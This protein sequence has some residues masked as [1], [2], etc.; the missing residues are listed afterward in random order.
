MVH[1]VEFEQ[2]ARE[3]IK[4][5]VAKLAHA[6]RTTLGP[7][8]RNVII[9]KSFG[10]PIVTKD[11][12]TVAQEIELED[13]Y[14]NVGAQMVREVASKTSDVAG[15][16][17]TTATVLA[18]AIFNEGLKVTTAG[19]NP[20][21]LARGMEK[22]V[23]D[24]VAK[25]RTWSIPVKGRK[26]MAQVA[27]IAANNDSQI[28]GS[29]ADAI[30]KVGKDGVV[31][32]EEG[33]TLTIDLECV[34]GMR[35]K[36]GYLSP[37]F[38][39]N[40][41]RMEC[42]L[43]D[44]Y[45]LI[46]EKKLSHLQELLPLLEM[47]AE[48]GKP[49]LIIAENV[50]GEVL[51]T[52]VINRLRGTFSSCAV[53]A[54]AYGDRRR[55][56]LED[57]AILSNSTAIMEN[58]GVN[59]NNLTLNKLGRAKQVVIDNEYTTIIEGAGTEKAVKSRIAQIDN[60]Y[61]KSTSESDR[62]QLLERKAKLRGGVVKIHVGGATEIEVKQKKMRFDDA[63]S[64]TRAAVAEGVLPGGGVALLRAATDCRPEGLNHDEAAGYN[65]IRRACR[66]PLQWI[67]ANAGQPGSVVIAH[68][69]EGQ[70]NFGFNAAT[71]VY[72]DL[73]KAGV[74]DA[75]KVVRCALENASSVATLLLTSAAVIAEAPHHK[76]KSHG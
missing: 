3:A 60:E 29:I 24:I 45:I 67:A 50:E 55:A 4:R 22:C 19:V 48:S 11:G 20:I 68:V 46:H 36:A 62:E 33:K 65:I 40:P 58:L 30:Q 18:N 41:D 2:N 13:K 38:V 64:A 6:V 37:Y 47:I 16:G 59:L 35:F 1:K 8:G 34:Q 27:T 42:V 39:T 69:L 21:E 61:Q 15:D 17:T 43:D 25:L 31:T 44:P 71:H 72:E 28:G 23:D 52:L 14:E 49:L 53:K 70:G 12:V 74:I 56:Q 9:E 76:E 66:A 5:G 75:T 7:G 57:L 32:I 51:T 63:L 10:P 26:E 73:V 54:P